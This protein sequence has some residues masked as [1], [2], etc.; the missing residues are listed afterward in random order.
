V[1]ST[2]GTAADFTRVIGRLTIATVIVLAALSLPSLAASQGV[3][4]AA[5]PATGFAQPFAGTPKYE[6]YAPTQATT[7]RQVNRPLG[8]KAADR[9]ARKLGL[10][11]RH[12]FTPKQYRLF[13]TGRGIGGDP[14]AA[15][16]RRERPDLHEHDGPSPLRQ[17]RWHGDAHRAR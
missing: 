8:P 11:K 14:A 9:I 12:A 13:I 2:A 5:T 3:A 17:C 6:K 15:R 1:R 10:D 7:A 16:G 4:H